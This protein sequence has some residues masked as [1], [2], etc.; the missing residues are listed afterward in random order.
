MFTPPNQCSV[1]PHF[2][3]AVIGHAVHDARLVRHVE[4]EMAVRFLMHFL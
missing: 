2:L 1:L 3:D 4:A